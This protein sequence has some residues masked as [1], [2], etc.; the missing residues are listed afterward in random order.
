MNERKIKTAA[1]SDRNADMY[2]RVWPGTDSV[3]A[4]NSRIRGIDV[5]IIGATLTP[6]N[7]AI[8]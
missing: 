5:L 6:K 4:E 3:A 2:A 8:P 1:I 7:P